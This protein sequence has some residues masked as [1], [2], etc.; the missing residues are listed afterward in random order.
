MNV[1]LHLV[2]GAPGSGKST[3]LNALLRQPNPY[4]AFDIDW[5][6]VPASQLARSNIIFDHTTWPA[7]NALWLEILHAI[8]RN[9]KQAVLFSPWDKGDVARLGALSWCKRI[10][11]LLL[12]CD[13]AS[14][15]ARLARRS[16]WTTAMIDEAI[17][18]A[19]VLREQ[20]DRRIDTVALDPDQ[21][22]SAILDWVATTT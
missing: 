18:D 8:G 7:Y 16:S 5:L 9:N 4:I 1:I 2:S 6:T 19:Q 17:E 22:A 11:W 3:A 15:R 21:V 14:R 20:I 10:E 13:D 12:D